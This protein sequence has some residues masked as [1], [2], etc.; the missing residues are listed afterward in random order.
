MHVFLHTYLCL[1]RVYAQGCP[2]NTS[3]FDYCS[4]VLSYFSLDDETLHFFEVSFTP[5]RSHNKLTTGEYRLLHHSNTA[6]F[7]LKVHENTLKASDESVEI[8]ME[9]KEMCRAEYLLK[10]PKVNKTY[11][12]E[13]IIK[14]ALEPKFIHHGLLRMFRTTDPKLSFEHCIE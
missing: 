5:K 10:L 12:H 1:R 4:Y 13:E 9:L 6:S 14:M 8:P 11:V 7:F 3:Y 2:H